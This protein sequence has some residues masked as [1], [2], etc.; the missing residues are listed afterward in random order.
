MSEPIYLKSPEH[1]YHIAY[2]EKEAR[3]HEKLG[4]KKVDMAKELEAK[5]KKA[6]KDAD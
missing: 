1:G 5:N 3:D 6:K 4:F 2:T